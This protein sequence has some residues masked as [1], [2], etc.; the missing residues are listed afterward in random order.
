MRTLYKD[1]SQRMKTAEI[2]GLGPGELTKGTKDKNFTTGHAISECDGADGTDGGEDRVEK[3]VSKL[4]GNRGDT[5]V[6][7]NDGVEVSET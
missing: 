5:K 7:E 6:G 3:V 1:K 4:L 2:D